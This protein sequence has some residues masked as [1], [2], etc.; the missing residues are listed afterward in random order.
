MYA[1]CVGA[2]YRLPSS[3][4]L[5]VVVVGFLCLLYCVIDEIFAHGSLQLV[6]LP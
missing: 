4:I 1:Y 5:A 6:W 2:S 3:S